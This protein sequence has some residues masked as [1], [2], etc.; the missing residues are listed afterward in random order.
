[1]S[2]NRLIDYHIIYTLALIVAAVT[3]AGHTWVSGAGGPRCPS[4]SA[5]SGPSDRTEMRSY[6]RTAWV[7]AARSSASISIRHGGA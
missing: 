3:Y 7:V 2:T 1:M 5:S 6:E 4:Y